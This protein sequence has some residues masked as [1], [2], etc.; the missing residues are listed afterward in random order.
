MLE[1]ENTSS[2][3]TNERV[4]W[5]DEVGMKDIARVG[6][7]NASL[8]EMI[9]HLKKMGVKVPEGFAITTKAFDDFIE[10][11]NLEDKISAALK[12]L[13]SDNPTDV[14]QRGKKIRKLFLEADFPEDVKR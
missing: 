12:G 9:G 5:L 11:N 7:K 1:G 13:D 3:R 10:K 4:L 8:G 14:A 6:G 2:K